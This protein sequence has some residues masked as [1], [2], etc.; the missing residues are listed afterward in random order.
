MRRLKTEVDS[1]CDWH[2]SNQLVLK[3]PQ[4][5]LVKEALH[6]R[7]SKMQSKEQL[8]PHAKMPTRKRHHLLP[9][10]DRHTESNKH[11][12]LSLNQSALGGSWE[13]RQTQISGWTVNDVAN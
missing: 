7:E 9:G 11:K 1:S 4:L 5:S 2:T 12:R 10:H 3:F 13:Q 8:P 6:I